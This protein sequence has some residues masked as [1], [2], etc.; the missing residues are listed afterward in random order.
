MMQRHAI[1]LWWR[2]Q[3]PSPITEA[4]GNFPRL[5]NVTGK[6]HMPAMLFGASHYEDQTVIVL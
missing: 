1:I 3:D 2:D 6:G 4:K 5:P